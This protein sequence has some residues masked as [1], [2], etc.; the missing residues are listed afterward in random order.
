[1]GR[2]AVRCEQGVVSA[3]LL[4]VGAVAVCSPGW[5]RWV[6]ATCLV[7]LWLWIMRFLSST[8]CF[9]VVTAMQAE[10]NV[11]RTAVGAWHGSGHGMGS[12]VPWC[13]SC[14]PLCS[15]SIPCAA[16]LRAQPAA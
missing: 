5:E 12:S 10:P 13:Q 4:P 15:S 6:D 8:Q 16:R 7:A 9:C 2:R 11:P 1:M 3:L 14:G